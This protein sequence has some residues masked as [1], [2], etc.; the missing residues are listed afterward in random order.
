MGT[1][2]RRVLVLNSSW[3]PIGVTNVRTALSLLFSSYNCGEP[4]SRVLDTTKMTIHQANELLLPRAQQITDDVIATSTKMINIPEAIIL[5]RYH[6]V[7]GIEIP[8]RRRRFSRSLMLQR[9]KYTC[10]YCGASGA[11]V[12]LTVDHVVP[13][14]KG[15]LTSFENCVTCCSKCNSIKGSRTLKEAGMTLRDNVQLRPPVQQDQLSE[16]A[17]LFDEIIQRSRVD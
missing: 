2:G 11:K 5:S 6:K 3:L 8:T 16:C 14:S 12:R 17:Q 4:K 10:A 15:G 1:L 7:P 9:D 13:Q